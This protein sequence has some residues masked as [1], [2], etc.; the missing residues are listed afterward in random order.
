[1]PQIR[2]HAGKKMVLRFEISI[3]YVWRSHNQC[4]ILNPRFWNIL[5]YF[6]ILEYLPNF[7][8][9]VMLQIMT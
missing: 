5:Q 6:V 7:E 8:I 9:L 1:M 3:Q 2:A 4:K